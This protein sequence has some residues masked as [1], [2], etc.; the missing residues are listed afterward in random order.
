[1]ARAITFEKNGSPSVLKLIELAVP[2]PA[3][4]QVRIRQTAIE[5]NFI[6]TM[7][8]SGIYEMNITPKT[9]GISAVGV[10]EEIGEGVLGYK[11]GDRVGYATANSG[12][13][14]TE[15]CINANLL[16]HIPKEIPDKVAAACLVK[17]LTAHYLTTRAFVISSGSSIVVHAASGATGQMLTQWCKNIGAFVI[18]TVGSDVKKKMALESGCNEVINYTTENW[19]EVVKNITKNVGVN[20][21]YDSVGKATFDGSLEVLM[22]MGILILYGAS[23]GAVTQLDIAKIAEKSLFFT[24]PSL[25]HYKEN[26]QELLLSAEELFQQL[27][28][29][30][31]KVR[32]HAEFPLSD[33]AKAHEMLESRQ[34]MGSVILIP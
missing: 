16:F 22:K 23:S 32:L 2:K 1:M 29:G 15:R 31:L 3:V 28:Q 18:G 25:F 4:G 14:C 5:V 11:P 33:A 17:G 9:P 10:I 30:L 12:S 21:V 26:R 6:D 24:R 34:T 7:Q 19:V 8:R 13:Y 20:A 27:I